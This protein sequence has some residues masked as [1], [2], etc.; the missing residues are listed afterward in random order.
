MN[1][2]SE[3]GNNN[4]K[5]SLGDELNKVFK[6]GV[7]A[8]AG[9]VEKGVGFVQELTTEGTE[10]NKRAAQ[11]GDDLTRK[12]G[13]TLEKARALGDQ[14][15]NWVI[16]ADQS[17]DEAEGADQSEDEAEGADA[18][19]DL[20]DDQLRKVAARAD[21]LLKARAPVGAAPEQDEN[22]QSE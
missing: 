8:V 3:T 12:G 13:E 17:E 20:S 1:S 4:H 15:K 9:A 11:M 21:E 22:Q 2:M 19:D 16:G 10:T 6:M 7:G 18:L 14:L 5:P